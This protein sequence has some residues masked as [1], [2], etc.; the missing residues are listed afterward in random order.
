[1]K[2]ERELRR[3]A[4]DVLKELGLKVRPVE[5]FLVSDQSMR[6]LNKRFRRKDKPTSILSFDFPK[7]PYPRKISKPLGEI[8]L[9]PRFIRIQSEDIRELLIHGLLHLLGYGHKRK[10]DKMKM[11]RLEEKLR[12]KLL[13]RGKL[14]AKQL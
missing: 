13:Q 12:K 4:K 9:A 7:I 10:S 5:I 6:G 2:L 14:K 11:E 8:Y 3:L 1:M